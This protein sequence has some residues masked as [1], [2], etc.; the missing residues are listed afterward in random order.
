MT[1]P[2]ERSVRSTTLLPVI[3]AALACAAVAFDLVGVHRDLAAFANAQRQAL[4]R[5]AFALAWVES[6]VA[7]D[8][9]VVPSG[10][11]AERWAPT[12]TRLRQALA[13]A[14][15]EAADAEAVWSERQHALENQLERAYDL[16]AGG[17]TEVSD[18]LLED[19]WD[20]FVDTWLRA[21]LAATV[22]EAL[23]DAD[24]ATHR[25]E[26]DA[27]HWQSLVTIDAPVLDAALADLHRAVATQ[28]IASDALHAAR[29]ARL[30]GATSERAR[31]SRDL[32]SRRWARFESAR[33]RVE[34]ERA[35]ALRALTTAVAGA[36]GARPGDVH[37]A[38]DV[39]HESIWPLLHADAE[40]LGGRLAVVERASARAGAFAIGFAL[41]ALVLPVIG[42]LTVSRW[43]TRPLA[44]T[45]DTVEAMS[46]GRLDDARMRDWP[47]PWR[48]FGV[49]LE[50]I[51]GRLEEAEGH[52]R[53]LLL[54][55][56]TTGLV[57]RRH[58]TER[59]NASLVSARV[60]GRTMAL[61]SIGIDGLGGLHESHRPEEYDAL[62]REVAQR[63]SSS[64]RVNDVIGHGA[65]SSPLP[66]V[67][68]TSET[69]LTVLLTKIA[70][71]SDAAIVAERT[72]G[73]FEKPLVV[74][75]LGIEC[76]VQ[77]S[78]GIAISPADGRDTGELLRNAQS[79][80]AAAQARGSGTALFCSDALNAAA[81]R[82]YEVR[83]RLGR[84]L[85]R[86]LLELHYQPIRD[87]RS[88]RVTAIEALLRW[89]DVEFGPISP[90]EFI[91]IA[92]ESG[93]ISTIGR[94]VVRRACEDIV[95]WREAGL[96]P[97]RVS[98]NASPAQLHESDFA[99]FVL[100]TLDEMKVSPEGI[101]L[102]ITESVVIE[103]NAATG[104]TLGRLHEAGIGL[105]L[106]DF[107]TGYSSFS[108]LRRFPIERVK[109]DRSFIA[110]VSEGGE[111]AALTSAILAFASSLGLPVVAEGVETDLQADFLM[112]MGCDEMQGYLISQAV[113]PTECA[114]FFELEK[115]EAEADSSGGG[116]LDD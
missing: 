59:L 31:A 79:A 97:V 7:H 116:E 75:E 105:V 83:R 42:L 110:E 114:R 98:I 58:F 109:I 72:L 66:V 36:P 96:A 30:D 15:P 100:D 19:G 14:F 115:P 88:G 54:Y 87:T 90:G 80:R 85:E 23:A 111:G 52:A 29:D 17:Q 81:S 51:R 56:A 107:G 103:Q 94:W 33:D 76:T 37:Q 61:L 78:I 1:S 40:R 6:S 65:G 95:G 113:S 11:D 8:P 49:D 92:E 18:R 89:S 53:A 16:R 104:E 112:Q 77:V 46:E 63:V 44:R 71:G 45:L 99:D 93:L 50:Q 82:K 91:P 3:V 101:E 102:E 27:N 25:A 73:A 67:G 86:D 20:R 24:A 70:A 57:N 106:D 22:A 60:D 69:E 64:V 84:A 68:Q 32:L 13:E 21:D 4:A 47:R 39:V 9:R 10:A 35:D 74:A 108:H 62:L 43:L 55:D 26:D 34:P 28:R 2:I 12:R 41:V 48:A 38:L 5:S